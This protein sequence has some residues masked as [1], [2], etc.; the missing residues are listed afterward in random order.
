VTAVVKTDLD[1]YGSPG[2]MTDL[3]T[4]DDSLFETL[5]DPARIAE[6]RGVIVHR[7]WTDSYGVSV[8]AA[9]EYE[10][11]TRSAAA[12]VRCVLEMDRRSH[13]RRIAGALTGYELRHACRTE[14][15]RCSRIDH[16]S[17]R[18]VNRCN[19]SA[20][21]DVVSGA[22]RPRCWRLDPPAPLGHSS[23]AV[24]RVRRS[25]TVCCWK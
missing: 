22:T 11:Q 19:V 8:P 7:F 20:A 12:M 5:D 18:V 10:L 16:Q 1:F 3:A 24:S 21:T 9:L 14:G 23:V 6:V 17:T 13:R 15:D 4:F 25:T 2:V